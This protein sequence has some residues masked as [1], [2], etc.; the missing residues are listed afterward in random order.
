MASSASTRASS[1]PSP[2]AHETNFQDGGKRQQLG[3]NPKGMMILVA[4]GSAVRTTSHMASGAHRRCREEGRQRHRV[5]PRL[6]VR[7]TYNSA[8]AGYPTVKKHLA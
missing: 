3:A 4:G 2:V 8:G 5:R 1:R 6:L 7:I